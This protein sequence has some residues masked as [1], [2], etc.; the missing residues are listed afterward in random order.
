MSVWDASGEAAL[1]AWLSRPIA[2]ADV[3]DTMEV[4]QD[5][6]E[7]LKGQLDGSSTRAKLNPIVGALAQ[8]IKLEEFIKKSRPK[9]PDPDQLLEQQNAVRDATIAIIETTVCVVERRLGL[10]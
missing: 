2:R 4:I 1:V 7:I 9:E 8:M 5:I 6:K 3:G 10:P